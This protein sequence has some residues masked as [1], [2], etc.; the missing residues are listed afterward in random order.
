[1]T[2]TMTITITAADGEPPLDPAFLWD[3]EDALREEDDLDLGL[4]LK[5]RPPALGEQG[6][7]PIGLEVVAAV[8]ALA[9]LVVKPFA[10][11]FVQ[12]L[13]EALSDKIRRHGVAVKLVREDG[14]SIDV[15]AQNAA[16]VP[17]LEA[18]VEKFLAEE[19]PVARQAQVGPEAGG[20]G[21]GGG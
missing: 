2:Q 6:A 20:G 21:G 19:G 3:L 11:P 5:E 8:T 1:M 12:T 15:S 14:R 9:K 4:E 17:W 10:K 18:A 13:A 16:D 7:V